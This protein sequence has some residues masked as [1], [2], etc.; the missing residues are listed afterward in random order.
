MS[1]TIDHSMVR[2]GEADDD[3]L[4]NKL[5][6]VNMRLYK[7]N[8]SYMAT[9]NRVIKH[10]HVCML[11]HFTDYDTIK[12]ISGANVGIPF[13]IISFFDSDDNIFDMINPTIIR[14]S[15]ETR[16]VKSNCGSLVLKEPVE[17]RRSKDIDVRYF[18]TEGEEITSTFSGKIASTI[19]HEVEHNLGIL[20]ID[21][22]IN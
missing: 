1:K 14:Y 4:H 5:F 19:Q 16:V 18:N 2:N 22:A 8:K 17:V 13:N 6:P 20:V 9:V 21:K 7:K 12:G 15:E 11:T 10:M 3:C